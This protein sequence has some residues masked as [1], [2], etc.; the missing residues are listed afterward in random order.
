M[1]LCYINVPFGYISLFSCIFSA[2][3]TLM[4]FFFFS[5]FLF[6]LVYGASL[7]NFLYKVVPD[8]CKEQC[9]LYVNSTTACV[10]KSGTLLGFEYN[11][12]DGAV[13]LTTGNRLA[14]YLCLCNNI[15][16]E[17]VIACLPCLSTKFCFTPTLVPE[18]YSS[19]C[20]GTDIQSIFARKTC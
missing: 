9:S 10:E 1:I 2:I 3:E 19:V 6:S 12:V 8:E 16:K 15:A 11:P 17:Q 18:D 4:H 20:S 5:F 14:I 13:K 7:N